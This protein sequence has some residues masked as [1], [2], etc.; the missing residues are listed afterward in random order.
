MAPFIPPS[1][2]SVSAASTSRSRSRS[3]SQTR[4]NKRNPHIGLGDFNRIFREVLKL[5]P[6]D[7]SSPDR[8]PSPPGIATRLVS[9]KLGNLA[10]LHLLSSFGHTGTS[11]RI[12]TS[13]PDYHSDFK[14]HSKGIPVSSR[15]AASWDLPRLSIRHPGLD[16]SQQT[17][18]ED[19]PTI[20]T[21]GGS[22]EDG[23]SKITTPATTPDL[24]ADTSG[25]AAQ[26][27]KGYTRKIGAVASTS[28]DESKQ[29]R[30]ECESSDGLSPKLTPS[31]VETWT[32][33]NTEPVA[34]CLDTAELL[35]PGLFTPLDHLPDAVSS[36]L[37]SDN[38]A[39][40]RRIRKWQAKQ[41]IPAS[42][43]IY[44]SKPAGAT[45]VPVSAHSQP[46]LSVAKQYRANTVTIVALYN[47]VALGDNVILPW[48]HVGDYTVALLPE[49]QR[50]GLHH[51]GGR[52][53]IEPLYRT[54][55]STQLQLVRA[56]LAI[57]GIKTASSLLSSP[58][59]IP[60]HLS[61]V[62]QPVH[63]FVDLS[64]IVISFC[65]SRQI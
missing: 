37:R 31:T 53:N 8:A 32:W 46:F 14:A 47:S 13:H 38:A 20:D 33:T 18:V 48:D 44:P 62:L 16:S 12:D 64:N 9:P 50:V 43:L 60:Q 15:P 23:R 5:G 22:N 2:R 7:H 26:R 51:F 17:L 25:L 4:R 36:S 34:T 45:D 30:A 19:L 29:P 10:K 27:I 40:A 61:S 6:N 42:V 21:E 65:T 11:D 57:Q 24:L 35:D 28:Q 58:P 39:D 63:V 41:L 3:R 59:A 1:K 55:K 52:L 54:T 56:R 49:H